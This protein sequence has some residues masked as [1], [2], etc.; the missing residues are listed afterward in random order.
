MSCVVLLNNNNN[1]IKKKKPLDKRTMS[2]CMHI[3]TNVLRY[4]DHLL[5]F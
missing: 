3:L 2:K 4:C 5:F 1:K